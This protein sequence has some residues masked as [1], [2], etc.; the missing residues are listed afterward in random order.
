MGIDAE[1]LS[2]MPDELTIYG[3]ASVDKYGKRTFSGSG[4]QVRCRVQYDIEQQS[5]T[6]GQGDARTARPNGRAFCFGDVNVST[7][8]RLVLPGNVEAI[9][10]GVN[11]ERDESGAHHTVI[12]FGVSG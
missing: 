11:R 12:H 6:N 7:D 2:L 3:Q 4:T 5:G 10:R 9:I 1:F 8:H